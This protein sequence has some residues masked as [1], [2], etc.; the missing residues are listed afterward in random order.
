MAVPGLDPGISPG[1]PDDVKRHASR[2]GI[3]G[4]RP[5]MTDGEESSYDDLANKKG[6]PR[7]ALFS[8]MKLATHAAR[9]VPAF[10]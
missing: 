2:I 9:E 10:L 6:G 8:E 4:T 7:A 1:H 5:V 3:T